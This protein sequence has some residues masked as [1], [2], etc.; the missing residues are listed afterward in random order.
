MSREVRR[1]PP[2]WVHPTYKDQGEKHGVN[3]HHFYQSPTAFHPMF[4]RSYEDAAN[5]WIKE[6]MAWESE[7]D[8]DR[9]SAEEMSDGKRVYF[10]D[11]HGTPPSDAYYRD[12]S[13]TPEEATAYQL[14]ETVSE[15][16]PVSPVF[17]T[18]DELE[19]WLVI[20]RGMSAP[21]AHNLVTTGWAPSGIMDQS[22]GL[23]VT[24]LDVPQYFVDR[25]NEKNT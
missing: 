1:V 5:D 4:D 17:Q 18:A 9:L 23:F 3:A 6:F 25:E 12:R 20:E 22:R 21:A 15:G 11:W 13:W 10:W 16:T 2:D 24:G 19:A 7:G 8:P 14:Y